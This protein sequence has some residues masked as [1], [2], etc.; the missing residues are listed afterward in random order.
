MKTSTHSQTSA[1]LP[2]KTSTRLITRALLVFAFS[3]APAARAQQQPAQQQPSRAEAARADAALAE[4]RGGA[5]TV[6][7][8][9]EDNQPVANAVVTAQ[10]LGASSSFVNDNSGATTGRYVLSNLDPGVYQISVNAAG[11][12]PDYDPNA[13]PSERDL[14]RPGDTASFRLVKGGVITGRVL[15]PEGEPAVGAAVSVVRVRDAAG[16][17]A[18]GGFQSFYLRWRADDRG[19]YRVFGLP[20]GAYL[21]RAGGRGNMSFGSRPSAYDSDAPT[22]YPSTTRDGA[23]EVQVQAGQEVTDIDVRHRGERGHSVSGTVVGAFGASEF[24]AAGAG[25]SLRRV[26]TTETESFAYVTGTGETRSFV[27]DGIAD[28]DYELTA[29]SGGE[30]EKAA[31]TASAPLRVPVRGADVVGLRLALAPLASVAGRVVLEPLAAADA[32]RPECK[33]VRPPA[34]YEALVSATRDAGTDANATPYSNTAAHAPDERGEFTLR[35]IMPGRYRLGLRLADD[36]LFARSVTQAAAAASQP[37][38]ASAARTNVADN[39]R[40]GLSV[41]AG[42]RLAG[43]TVTVA[44]GAASLRGRLAAADDAE[45]PAGTWRVHLVPAE[46]ERAEDVLRY[47][48]TLARPD[49]SFAFKHLAPGRYHLTARAVSEAE[50]RRPAAQ[51]RRAAW[52]AAARAELR[53]EAEA[54][55]N[56]FALTPCQRAEDL[57][58]RVGAR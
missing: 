47:A 10:R 36:N 21:V 54:A 32:A 35:N 37:A 44:Q 27:M 15:D 9:G 18:S 29:T 49:G 28:G 23:V 34:I 5:I 1:R 40:N 56:A 17:P 38:A 26:N 41:D 58:L 57:T 12:V 55:K 8:L 20:A 11:F 51:Q 14:Y 30:S 53:R 24:G 43:V 45:Q 16:R 22:Y 19:V 33:G 52:D 13:D 3:L 46:P 4:T 2:L 7:V 31:G 42:E 48:E 25:V 39:A 6:R 50:L